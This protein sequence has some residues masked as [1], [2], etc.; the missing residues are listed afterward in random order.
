MS[1][2]IEINDTEITK[3]QNEFAK[4][5]EEAIDKGYFKHYEYEYFNNIQEV[6]SGGFG[7]VYRAKWK[8][9]DKFLALKS[10]YNFDNVTIKEIVRELKLQRDIQF[11][12][13]VIKFY[14]LTKLESES[15]AA[16][17]KNYMFVMEY[18]NDG[19][20][21]N[22]LQKN[23]NTLTW[24]DKCKLA[25]QLASAV[26]CLHNEEIV[27]RDLH[28]GNVLIHQKTI[29]LADFGLSRRIG[30][31]SKNQSKIFAIEILQGRREKPIPGTPIDYMKIYTECWHEN[32]DNRPTINQ[33]IMNQSQSLIRVVL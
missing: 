15:N 25:Y 32:P 16:Q 14:G 11:H 28:S 20:L 10:F 2:D 30:E 17:L 9:S 24:D 7:K 22:Y 5:I 1:S 3:N 27:H 12:D 8:N 31:T 6:G 19:S 26:S 18:A 23:F 33:M 13:N 4:W 21:Q 29:K